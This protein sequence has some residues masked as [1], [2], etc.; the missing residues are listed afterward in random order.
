LCAC[1]YVQFDLFIYTTRLIYMCDVTHSYVR[2]GSFICATCH[3][4]DWVMLCTWLHRVTHAN[5]S[6]HTCECVLFGGFAGLRKK[7][8]QT[9]GKEK[10]K[11]ANRVEEYIYTYTYT[12]IY[13]NTYIYKYTHVCTHTCVMY[14]YT[15]AEY[16]YIYAHTPTHMYLTRWRQFPFGGFEEIFQ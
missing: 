7:P 12:C 10:G 14:I 13:V 6:C 1:A 16:I 4:Y 3:T 5:E 9:G 11:R 15:H 8:R 2:R